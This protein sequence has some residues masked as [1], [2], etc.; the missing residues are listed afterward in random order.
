M[1]V[2]STIINLVKTKFVF[3]QYEERRC[4][5]CACFSD[6]EN[7]YEINSLNIQF[8]V[9]LSYQSDDSSDEGSIYYGVDSIGSPFEPIGETINEIEVSDYETK[10]FNVTLLDSLTLIFATYKTVTQLEIINSIKS[11]VQKIW[12]VPDKGIIGLNIKGNVWESR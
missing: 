9:T 4:H 5:S 6:L 1:N 11:D 2:D 12:V 3:N 8:R 10:E 7:C